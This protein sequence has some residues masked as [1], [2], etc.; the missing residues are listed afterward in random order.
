MMQA[1]AT[2]PRQP[3]GRPT[4][5]PVHVG[6]HIKEDVLPDI[7]LSIAEAAA[8]IGVARQSLYAVCGGKA[9]LSPELAVRIAKLAGVDARVLLSWQ[10]Y[11]DIWHAEE[12]LGAELKAIKTRPRDEERPARARSSV[13][14]HQRETGDQAHRLRPED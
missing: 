1:M 14:S 5:P 11:Y 6:E 3:A 2:T 7:G 12:K 9:A 10:A 8:A 13:R 4:R